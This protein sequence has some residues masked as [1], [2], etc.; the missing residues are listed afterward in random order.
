MRDGFWHSTV[1]RIICCAVLGTAVEA[2]LA[3]WPVVPS[4]DLAG[5]IVGALLFCAWTWFVVGR[6]TP[7]ETRTHALRED[8]GR[9]VGDLILIVAALS[10]IIG[11][12]VLIDASAHKESS[13]QRAAIM[14]VLAVA[15]SWTVVHTMFM[16]RYARQYFAVKPGGIDFNSDDDPEND[17]PD[18]HDFAYLAFTIGMTYQVSDST[19]TNKTM[20]RTAL[21]HA[22]LSFLLGAVILGATINLVSQLASAPG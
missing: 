1:F 20:R 18:Y 9:A 10:A 13:A 17:S 2:V 21:R 19:F 12:G 15:A 5:W 4:A 6:L 8:P 11:V 16:L 22:L 3:W 7:D 14:G